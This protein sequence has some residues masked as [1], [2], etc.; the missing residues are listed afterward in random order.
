MT[1]DDLKKEHF[2]NVSKYLGINLSTLRKRL[3]NAFSKTNK[4]IEEY[5]D[6]NEKDSVYSVEIFGAHRFWSRCTKKTVHDAFYKYLCE[7]YKKIKVY[8]EKTN[9]KLSSFQGIKL[10]KE[11]YYNQPSQLEDIDEFIKDNCEI[12]YVGRITSKEIYKGFELWKKQFDKDY[13][14][15]ALEKSRIDHGFK[16]RF[17]PSCVYIGD[18][19]N[20]HGYFFV[21]LKN[22]SNFVGFKLAPKL[23]KKIIK[24]DINTKQIVD[25]FES[26]ATA[27]NSINRSSSVL[28][29]DIKYKKPRDNFIFQYIN[30]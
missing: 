17:L 28:S 9:A 22:N 30:T 20:A 29:S 23:K 3:A 15:C 26:L 6:K 11:I 2:K 21:T 18:K 14:L 24:I 10:K 16:Y 7:N 27:A 12:N 8:D 13:V 25:T 5:C 19:G 1:D 4:F